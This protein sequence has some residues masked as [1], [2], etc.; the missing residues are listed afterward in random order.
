M[1]DVAHA[2]ATHINAAPNPMTTAT[3]I[4]VAMTVSSPIWRR[5]LHDAAGLLADLTAIVVAAITV[6]R[7]IVMYREGKATTA[8]AAKASGDTSKALSAAA[9]TSSKAL[10][11][12][13]LFSAAALA[14]ATMFGKRAEAA[15]A[16]VTQSAK[17][18]KRRSADDAGEDDTD[19]AAP[20]AVDGPA[21]Y[22]SMHADIGTH[23]EPGARHNPKIVAYFR[24]AGWPSVK[25]DETAWCA[26]V[27]NAH[28][29]RNG[30][31]GT[32]LLAA[33]SF[34]KWGEEL[35]QPRVG[36]IVVMW[37]G[38]RTGWQGH[39]GLYVR[40]TATHIYVLGGNQSD[41]LTVAAFPKGRVLSY[42]WPRSI[43][44][45]VTARTAAGS[46][47]SGT[48]AEAARQGGPALEQT[49]VDGIMAPLQ[50]LGTYWRPIAVFAAALSVGLALWAVYRRYQDMQRR[51]V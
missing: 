19:T 14:L 6:W 20:V 22:R 35:Q 3:L 17:S 32:K 12:A 13:A 7:L 11:F 23:E 41:A 51:G 30:I 27:V 2:D 31:P 46:A 40:E 8:D 44:D 48:I 5:V 28:L 26:A 49:P 37:R 25:D 38:S 42:R 18:T 33:R 36:C 21:W 4:M 9:R 24:D 10:M 47:V 45:S 43:T 1:A 39:V 50:T 29:E 34:E 16:V 15:P